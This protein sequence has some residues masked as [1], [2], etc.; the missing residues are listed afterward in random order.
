MRL[1]GCAVV[2][3]THLLPYAVEACEE[4]VILSRG[5]VVAAAPALEL[6]GDDGALRYRT[7]LS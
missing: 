6:A 2:V 5:A 3:S 1:R 4:A 7:L